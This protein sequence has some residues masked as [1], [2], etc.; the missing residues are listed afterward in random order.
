[1][2]SRIALTTL[3]VSPSD[4]KKARRELEAL[5]ESLHQAGLRSGGKPTKMPETSRLI[6]ELASET[7][8]NLLQSG[9]RTQLLKY[10]SDL[11]TGAPVLH[12]SFASEPSAAFMTKLIIWLRTNIHPQVLVQLG[13]QPAIAAGCI[14]RTANKQFDFSLTQ[15]FENQQGLLIDS[16]REYG[17]P[18]ESPVSA[19]MAE[20]ASS[21]T[22]TEVH[23]DDNGAL[24]HVPPT[25]PT[26]AKTAVAK[27]ATA[28]ISAEKSAA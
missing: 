12:F 4:L 27:P 9:H 6:D 3:I 5:D 14:V 7:N 20:A 26:S 1:M 15:A 19:P 11:I 10:V 13:L 17:K 16:I 23:I 24:Q 18:D 21:A 28:K 25:A 2:A 8:A 22:S